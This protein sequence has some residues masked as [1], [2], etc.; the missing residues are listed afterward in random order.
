MKV[1][2]KSAEK[3]TVTLTVKAEADEVAET[4]KTV[5][6][7]YVRN[8]RIPGFRPGKAPLQIVKQHF[9]DD[10]IG[11]VKGT[12]FR[13][14]Y[15]EALKEAGVEALHLA[16]VTDMVFSPETGISFTAVV[17][18]KPEFKLPKYKK[19]SIDKL[20]V[21]VTDK[22]LD[23]RV[24]SLRKA[25]AKYE[26]AKEGVAV[27]EGDFV[28]I[29]YAG[30][31][32]GK[33]VLEVAP[34]AK[35]VAGATGFWLQVEEGRFLPEL[36]EALKGMKI[37]ETKSGLKVKFPKD[38]APEPL[39][40][41][42]AEYEITVKALRSRILPDDETFVKD[43]GA[44][45]LDK[46]R[47]DI[48][49]RMVADET[50]AEENRRQEYAIDL[51]LKKA[52]FDVPESQVRNETSA[53]LDRFA[54]QAQY[55]GLDADYVKDQREQI[56]AQAEE[57]AVR[58]VRLAYILAAIAKEENL[59]A[60]EEEIAARIAAIAEANRKKPEEVRESIEKAGNMDGLK[61][62]LRA[63]KALKLV[64]DESK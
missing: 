45:S 12:C 15:P 32:D 48:R 17:E 60:T 30:T 14:F 51:L 11:E 54:R 42:K 3:C 61:E 59:E 37:G 39:K 20:E 22:Q 40:G 55:S 46:L 13:K 58:Q 36:L 26:D 44:E 7:K 52:D 1:E 28:Q 38:A 21:N 49:A 34:E 19:L 9:G 18:V 8:V 10:I 63:E 53:N 56:L 24:E 50:R 41:K 27:A 62:Q 23:D 43:A 2:K 57:Q 33:P 47:E 16:D 25:Y 29:D 4:Y 31:V 64:V 35:A 6:N 5:L